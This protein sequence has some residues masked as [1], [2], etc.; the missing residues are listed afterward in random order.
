MIRDHAVQLYESLFSEQ[1]NWRPR[2]DNLDFD[3]LDA[4]EADRLEAP[5]E[6]REV[7][8]VVK[9]MDRDKASGSDGFSMAFFQDCWVVIK[10]DI[11]AV[12]SYLYTR[13]KFEKSLNA[14]FI[15]L[16]PKV[17][18]ASE[19]EFQPISLISGIY[20]IIAKF[21]A[22]RMRRVV[23]RVIS[24]PQ[25]AFVKGRQ[26]TNLVLIASECLD[27]CISSGEPGLLCKLDMEKAYDHMD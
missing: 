27:S 8:E 9:G 17:L 20:K 18:G 10:E 15:S 13:G 19:L 4:G 3:M 26:I 2:L 23:G 22:N 6:E 11:M 7:W 1:C 21:L 5:F 24:K 16:I 12:F 14:T 25:N